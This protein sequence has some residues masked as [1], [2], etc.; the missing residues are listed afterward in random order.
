MGIGNTIR[1][2][3]KEDTINRLESEL[4]EYEQLNEYSPQ[5]QYV[6]RIDFLNDEISKE[7][8]K[9]EELQD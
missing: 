8:E 7:N 6:E 3:I 5:D 4:L 9:L 1:I 2:K